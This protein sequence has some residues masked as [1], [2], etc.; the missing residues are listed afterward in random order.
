MKKLLILILSISM[1]VAAFSSCSFLG[2]DTSSSSEAPAASSSETS[3]VETPATSDETSSSEDS[4]NVEVEEK[5]YSVK[6]YSTSG[7]VVKTVEVKEGEAVAE[8][9]IPAVE[10][11]TGYTVVWETVDLSNVTADIE[12]KA[13]ATANTYTITFDANGGNA[14]EAT[15]VV[16]DTEIT[17]PTPERTGFNFIAWVDAEENVVSSG[18]WTIASDITLTATWNEVLPDTYT[19]NFVQAGQP[20]VSYT[21]EEGTTFTSIPDT[22][23]KT[24]YTVV[25]NT[26]DLAQLSNIQGNVT[27]N[28]V[29]TANTYTV[30][31]SDEKGIFVGTVEVTYDAAYDW[32]NTLEAV[33]GY[34]FEKLSLEDG[35]FVA[36]SGT[37][38]IA[39]DTTVVA[40]WTAKQY[41]VVLK[42]GEGGTCAQTQFTATYDANY[43]LPTV[44][45]KDGY[46]FKGWT[47]NGKLISSTGI[48]SY[49][50]TE[51]I[52]LIATWE[53][54]EWTKNY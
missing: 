21:V 31:Y 44:T 52:E 5:F 10:D 26:D 1:S 7:E 45:V 33:T 27:V 30:T 51:T 11:K 28:A 35:T 54:D 43:E 12:V 53:S 6:F 49:D 42:I 25:W 29:E 16:Y 47:L 15:S 41:T 38:T 9:D 17:L 4:S 48:W 13:V 37:W 19:V 34:N 14:I 3:S 23:A 50:S 18:K 32:S 22:V 39:N 40:N 46:T 2:G 20:V 36:M 24:G 8:A